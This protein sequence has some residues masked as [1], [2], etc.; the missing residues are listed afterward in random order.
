MFKLL[1]KLNK[2]QLLFIL[3]CVLF[4]TIQVWLDLKLPDYMTSITTLVQTKGS[5]MSSILIEGSKMMLCALGSLL[6]AFI[7]GYFASYTAASF[8]KNL[9]SDIFRKVESFGMEEIKKFSTSSLITRTTNDVTQVQMLMALGLQV[10]VKAPIMAVWAIYKIAGKNFYWS[11]STAIT[12]AIILLVIIIIIVLALPKFRKIQTLTDNINRVTRENLKGIR[13]VR[14]YNAEE[15]E[16]EKFDKANKE[17]TYTQMFAQRMMSLMGPVMSL[18]SSGLTLVIYVIGAY[19]INNASLMDRIG[20]F[21][22]MVVF[23]SYAMQ[24]IVAFMLLIM[25]FVIYPRSAVAAKRIIEVL[26]TKSSIKSGNV[27]KGK[28]NMVGEVEFKN[29]SFKYPDAESY[30]L[31]DISFKAKKGQMIAFIG[32]TG[33]GKSTLINLI[34]RFYDATSGEILVDGVNVKDYK[35]EVLND[36][37]GYVSQKAVMFSGTVNSNV[38]FGK[39]NNKKVT[40]DEV[41]KASTVALADEFVSNMQDKYESHIAQGGTNI[42][43][44]QKQRLQIARAIAKSPEIYIFDDS[45]SALDYKTDLKLRKNLKQYTKDA[46]ILIVAQRI[47][48]IMNADNIIVLDEGKIVGMGTHKQL[49]KNCDVY[50][51]IALSQLSEE[52]L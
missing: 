2:K 25:I 33:S 10:M 16:K 45:F 47:G 37:I 42:S 32:S 19:L 51:E 41:E 44:G 29:V 22:N 3:I 14:A 23:I 17:L 24:V 27:N 36:K 8:G 28:K 1:R 50:R 21:S 39:V 38:A 35:I 48:T 18:S 5:K 4:I 11:L 52:E 6:S 49:L 30:M 34:P 26:N 40:K 15:Y 9:R 20:L 12:V 7:T 46:T 31:K 13:V 43:G